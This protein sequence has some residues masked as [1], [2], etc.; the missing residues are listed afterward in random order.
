[1]EKKF[2]SFIIIFSAAVAAALIFCS[3]P[4]AAAAGDATISLSPASASAKVNDEF[5]IEIIV[6]PGSTYIDAVRAEISF[7][8]DKLEVKSFTLGSIYPQ[9]APNNSIDNAAGLLSEGGAIYNGETGLTGTFGTV[10][11]KAKAV[12]TANISVTSNSK[13]IRGGVEKID[14]TSLGSATVTITPA[15]TDPAKVVLTKKVG[16]N[17]SADGFDS[18]SGNS[19]KKDDVLTYQI[20]YQNIGGA[21]ATQL[22]LTDAMPTGTAY[23]P[24]SIKV[25]NVVKTDAADADVAEF[26]ANS[27]KIN[28]GELAAGAGGNFQ[29]KT[30]ILAGSGQTVTNSAQAVGLNISEFSNEVSNSIPAV[31]P[32][33]EEPIVPEEPKPETP[34]S[35]ETT[36]DKPETKPVVITGSTE[37]G[38][39]EEKPLAETPGGLAAT[40]EQVAEQTE[41]VVN[42]AVVQN[43]ANAMAQVLNSINSNIS[44][45]SVKQVTEQAVRVV[46]KTAKEARRANEAA[47]AP[48][49]ATVTVTTVAAV[50]S[51]GATSSTGIT[52]LT[53]A[54]FLI[55]QL[56]MFMTRRRKKGWGV[57]YNS[58]TKQPIDLAVIR[59]YEAGANKLLRTRV[60]DRAGRFQFILKPGKY[61]LKI[62]KPEFIFP[63]A[64]LN[65]AKTDGKFIDNYYGEE[66]EVGANEIVIPSIPLDPNRKLATHQ[67]L[68]KKYLFKR[69]QTVLTLIGPAVSIVS[70]VINPQIWVGAMVVLQIILYVVFKKIMSGRKPQKWGLVRDEKKKKSV[71]QAIVRVF[72]TKFNKLLETQVTD[73]KGRYAFLVGGQQY[74]LTGEKAGYYPIKTPI[75]NLEGKESGYLAED[76]LL[77]RNLSGK[78]VD[79]EQLRSDFLAK[80]NA[81]RQKEVEEAGIKKLTRAEDEKFRGTIKDVNLNELHEDFYNVDWVGG[82]KKTTDV[83]KNANEPA[84]VKPENLAGSVASIDLKPDQEKLLESVLIDDES[85]EA[86]DSIAPK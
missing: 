29:F 62:E 85:D 72:D 16:I 53:Y 70:F 9:P 42:S 12:G 59:V 64:L 25:G 82:V 8:P 67:S 63:S 86:D 21:K 76:L 69:W 51:V 36:A 49:L 11:F 7:P 30:K 47:K 3:V 68:L 20:S 79:L 6:S 38:A 44:A 75:Y 33:E 37:S 56:I 54:Q 66:F 50:A 17:V 39:T 78:S 74:Y 5:S 22:I 60:T 10:I 48:A 15:L 52:I 84:Q 27:V 80:S 34:A 81:G 57:V 46:V 55:S 61:Y 18:Q 43:T 1:M 23:V 13:L 31:V 65:K 45:E 2:F 14:L 24:G 32:E 40:E 77:R 58:I 41:Q 28:L 4:M 19:V 83:V 71:A 35:V 26:S 73:Y